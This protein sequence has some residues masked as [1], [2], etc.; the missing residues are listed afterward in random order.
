MELKKILLLSSLVACASAN[1][2]VIQG[3][4]LIDGLNSV[5]QDGVFN[6]DVNADQ[7]NPDE[8]WTLDAVSAGNTVM[9]FEVAGYANANTMGIYDLNSNAMLQLFAGAATTG[10]STQLKQVGNNFVATYFDAA[11][12]FLGQS[13]A[14]FGGDQAFGFYLNTPESNTFYSQA[15]KNGDAD[16][17]SIADDHLVAFQGDNVDKM[18]P[19]ADGNFGL[20]SDNNFILAWEDLSF[21]GSDFDFSD[22]VVM[23]ESFVPV[24][25]PG[26]LALLGLGLIG[27]G[28]ARR[29]NA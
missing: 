5:T 20:F 24:S 6:Q 7:Y 11:G 26:T 8:T 13:V 17:D 1:A 27:L 21:A 3:T 23:V 29:R 18:D 15:A 2:A 12:L 4:S 14:N 25:E 19:D 22:M 28:A 16:A 9:M 10:Y